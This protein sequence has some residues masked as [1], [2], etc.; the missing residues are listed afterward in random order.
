[1]NRIGKALTAAGLFAFTCGCLAASGAMNMIAQFPAGAQD[2]HL[3]HPG[4]ITARFDWNGSTE[5][6]KASDFPESF[7]FRCFDETGKLTA[8]ANAAWCIPVVQIET[9]SVDESGKPVSP[10]EAGSIST[11]LYGPD[12][13]FIEH[14]SSPPNLKRQRELD[15]QRQPG[16]IGSPLKKEAGPELPDF[17]SSYRTQ[18][19]FLRH[20]RV[21]HERELS[22]GLWARLKGWFGRT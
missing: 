17:R 10:S 3:P 15:Q 12:H 2:P 9:V 19:D 5:Q 6:W 18:G 11:T 13:T 1:M 21:V 8:R 14:I 7:V 22:P 16:T 20:K 4:T